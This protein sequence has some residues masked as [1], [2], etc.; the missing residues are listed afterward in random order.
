MACVELSS[1]T[2]TVNFFWVFA[3]NSNKV[4]TNNIFKS[5]D[6]HKTT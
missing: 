2:E 6:Y 1:A 3:R 5:K 4:I